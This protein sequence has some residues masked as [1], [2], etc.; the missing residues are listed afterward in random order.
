M[1]VLRLRLSE[2]CVSTVTSAAGGIDQAASDRRRHGGH[3]DATC[4]NNGMLA[5]GCR[6][7]V[8]NCIQTKVIHG[9]SSQ[10]SK[11]QQRPATAR[12][13]QL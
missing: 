7:L 10:S 11:G 3:G 2:G 9:L 8:A 12:R 5:E 4:T 6:V 13:P 1:T